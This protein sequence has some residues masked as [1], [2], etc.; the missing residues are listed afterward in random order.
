[1][2]LDVRNHFIALGFLLATGF[3]SAIAQTEYLIGDPMLEQQAMLELINRAR[4][5]FI[6][7]GTDSQKVIVR[8]LGPSTGVPGAMANPT[9]ELHD[10]NRVI[11]EANDDWQ[12]SANKQAI[13]DSGIPPSDD[14][15]SA[16]VRTLTPGNYTAILRG[17]ND[18]TGHRGRGSLCFELTRTAPEEL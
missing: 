8:A 16:I 17:T 12:Q 5:G 13:I 14:A 9:L 1:M 4:A 6:V 3:S 7:L 15:E 18:S 10:V 11:L 2:F